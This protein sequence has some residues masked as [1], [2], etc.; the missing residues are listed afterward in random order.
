MSSWRYP[1]RGGYHG[2]RPSFFPPG[3]FPTG[4]FQ[5]QIKSTK[6]KGGTSSVEKGQ[7]IPIVDCEDTSCGEETQAREELDISVCVVKKPSSSSV[8]VIKTET[9]LQEKKAKANA[10]LKGLQVTDMEL[11]KISVQGCASL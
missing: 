5:L 3:G 10:G 9:E 4:N 1:Y 6:G 11:L 2:G 8:K 7:I